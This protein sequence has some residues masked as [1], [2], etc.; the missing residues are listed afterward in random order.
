MIINWILKLLFGEPDDLYDWV[1]IEN[2]LVL[3]K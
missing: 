1:E 3:G 2:D